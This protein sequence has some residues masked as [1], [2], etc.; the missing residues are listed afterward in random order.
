MSVTV[1]RCILYA[2]RIYYSSTVEWDA[3]AL[4]KPRQTCPCTR[5][6][7]HIFTHTH[8]K[9]SSSVWVESL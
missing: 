4:D 2:C 9:I 7:R 1:P 8:R 3:I 5:S 6:Q